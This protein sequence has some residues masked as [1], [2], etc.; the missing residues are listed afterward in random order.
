VVT[1]C[2]TVY[3]FITLHVAQTVLIVVSLVSQNKEQTFSEVRFIQVSLNCKGDVVCFREG[4]NDAFKWSVTALLLSFPVL[5]VIYF[6][7]TNMI[8][9]WVTS[10]PTSTQRHSLYYQK[11]CS[12]ILSYQK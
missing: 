11:L 1:I 5:S 9:E 6:S 10:L 12:Q 4:K 2:T 8:F 7:E 3:T